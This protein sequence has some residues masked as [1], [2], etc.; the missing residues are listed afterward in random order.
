LFRQPHSGFNRVP[1][2]RKCTLAWDGLETA[3]LICNLSI[4]GAYVHLEAPLEQGRGVTLRFRLQDDGPE[5]EAAA[6]VSWIN[7]V[8]AKDPAGLPLGCGLRFTQVAPDDLRRI[9]ALVAEFLV[10]PREQVQVGIGQPFTGRVRIPFI[11]ACTLIG[12]FGTRQGHVC[13]LSTL[14]VYVAIAEIPAQG[15]R[16]GITFNLPGKDGEFTADFKVAWQ[17]PDSPNRVHALPPG[18]G[19]LFEH[20]GPREEKLLAGLVNDYLQAVA[21]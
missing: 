7:D 16:G 1:F 18:C 14:G 8:P 20:L 10:A 13:N 3:C 4:L 2:V 9:A 15:A 11:A 19:L 21:D 17:N 6:V 5:I 12:R